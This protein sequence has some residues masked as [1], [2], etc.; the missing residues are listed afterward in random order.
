MRCQACG[1]DNPPDA[2]YCGS[3][4]VSL[5]TRAPEV[6]SV[7]YCTGCGTSNPR[8]TRFCANCGRRIQARAGG[9]TPPPAALDTSADDHPLPVRLTVDYSEWESVPPGDLIANRLLLFI[10]WIFA[11]PLLIAVFFYSIAAFVALFIAFW[12]ILFTGRFPEGLFEFVRGYME[13]Q[14]RVYSYFPLLLT[15][16]WTPDAS[17]P[18]KVDIDYP[19]ENSRVALL[20]L[21]LPSF[22]LG[23]VGTLGVIAQGLLFLIAIPAWFMILVLGRYPRGWF[24][25]S[26]AMLEWSFRVTSWQN[27]LR[28]EASLFGTTTPVRVAAGIGIVILTIVGILEWTGGLY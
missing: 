20:L 6:E 2:S 9:D 23:V 12:V 3:C 4:G 21:K 5:E 25:L 1:A 27:L 19:E 15:N 18:V 7:V 11:I 28:D 26:P 17:H 24:Q 16:H 8:G 10:K 13:F 22:L 14:Y